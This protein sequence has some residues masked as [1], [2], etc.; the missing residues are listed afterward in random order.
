[1]SG[2]ETAISDVKISRVSLSLDPSIL[3]ERLILERLA[4]TAYSRQRE[5]LRMLIVQG[6]LFECRLLHTTRAPLASTHTVPAV[7]P[8]RAPRLGPRCA[9]S[10]PPIES[11]PGSAQAIGP[12]P[13]VASRDKPFATLRQV[14]GA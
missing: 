2:W 13:L 12:A 8:G 14:I 6:Y 7:A 4:Q 3:L 10:H 1:M 5:W 11:D 9:D